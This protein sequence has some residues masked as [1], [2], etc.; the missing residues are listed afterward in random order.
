MNKQELLE[1]LTK[2]EQ[3]AIS[4]YLD[5]IAFSDIA[6]QMLDEV[7]LQELSELHIQYHGM[8]FSC[9]TDFQCEYCVNYHE[10]DEE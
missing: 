2:L 8:C 10:K 4:R 3:T 6:L 5:D 9:G 1:A 7:E